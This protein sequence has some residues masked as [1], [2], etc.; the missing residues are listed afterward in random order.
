MSL[1]GGAL[2]WELVDETFRCWC[3]VPCVSLWNGDSGY[4]NLARTL[5]ALA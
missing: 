4:L 3:S 1:F 5:R 2:W